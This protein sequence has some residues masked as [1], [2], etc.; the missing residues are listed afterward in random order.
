MDVWVKEKLDRGFANQD[1]Q[2][3]FHEAKVWVLQSSSSNHLPLFL[4]LKKRVLYQNPGGFGS[5]I[6]G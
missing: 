5:K 4:G 2:R 6:C 3:M 1:W